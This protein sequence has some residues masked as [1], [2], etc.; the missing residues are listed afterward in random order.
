[1][2]EILSNKQ[3]RGIFG[4]IQLK[5]IVSK[6]LPADA[7]DFQCTLSNGKRADCIIYLPE[8][9]GNIVID[10]KFPLEAYNSMITNT[11]EV[12]K[13]RNTQLFQSSIKTHIKEDPKKTSL[14]VKLPM[15]NSILPSEAI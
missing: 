3:A 7:Y 11:N 10:S 8:P 1:M 6:A 12:E 9:Q 4:E 13:N 14:A 2:Q 15:C 5:D